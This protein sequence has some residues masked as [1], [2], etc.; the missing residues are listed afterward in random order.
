MER[1]TERVNGKL[2]LK[3]KFPTIEDTLN[4]VTNRLELYE[5]TGFTPEQIQAQQQEI[6]DWKDA[7]TIASNNNTKLK[8]EIEQIKANADLIFSVNRSLCDRIESLLSDKDEQAAK[9]MRLMEA[10][11]EATEEIE[12]IYGHDTPQTEKYRELLGG[13]EDGK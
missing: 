3:K 4:I 2:A 1:L 6:E 9:I 5:D 7:G 10:L 11:E 12:N 8:Q 13:A